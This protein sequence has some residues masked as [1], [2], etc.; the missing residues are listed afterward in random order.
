[1]QSGIWRSMLFI[2]AN[3][4]RMIIRSMEELQD[5][6]IFDLEDAVPVA[7]KETA[8]VFSRGTAAPKLKD[9]GN[10]CLRTRVNSISTGMTEEG[11]EST[12]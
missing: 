9:A 7:E 4:W 12:W 6:V 8:L 2:P 1:M 11:P 10:R 3:S 5:A